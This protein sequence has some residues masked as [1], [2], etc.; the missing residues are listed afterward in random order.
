MVTLLLEYYERE[1]EKYRWPR[2][3]NFAG[4]TVSSDSAANAFYQQLMNGASIGALAKERIRFVR[5]TKRKRGS[6]GTMRT[7]QMEA[8]ESSS[9][10]YG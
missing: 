2:R 1:K 9:N 4:L 10:A 3:V 5:D 8:F 7:K 6:L